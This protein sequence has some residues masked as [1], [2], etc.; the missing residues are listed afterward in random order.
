MQTLLILGTV[1]AGLLGLAFGSFLNVCLSRWPQGGNVTTPRSYCPACLR[2]LAWWENIPLLSWLL[3]KGRCRTCKATIGLR[4]PI[5]EFAVGSIWAVVVWR[6]LAQWIAQQSGPPI[7]YDPLYLQLE[8][9]AATMLL[10]WV[11]VGLAVLDAEHFWLPD[12]VTLPGIVAGILFYTLIFVQTTQF[13]SLINDPAF[14]C[15]MR[16]LAAFAGAGIVLLIRWVYFLFRRREGIGM[17]DAKLMAMLAAWLGF[18]GAVL[19]FA[20]GVLLATI[21]GFVVLSLESRERKA[22]DWALIKLPLGTFLCAGAM[23]AS[24]WGDQ[25]IGTYRQWVGF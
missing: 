9:A 6:L 10:S 12:A 24:L 5:V 4:H 17:G 22:E 16:I 21:A 2:T 3:L 13:Y 25:I 1:L 11:L 14:A 7:P 18:K 23:I 19:S 20:L 8:T 15:G